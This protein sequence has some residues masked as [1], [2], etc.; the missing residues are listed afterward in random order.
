M[1]VVGTEQSR[2]IDRM[3]LGSVSHSMI[4]DIEIPTIVVAPDCIV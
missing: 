3:L 2:G 4:L 1:L